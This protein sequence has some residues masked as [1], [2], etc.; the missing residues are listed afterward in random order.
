[1]PVGAPPSAS[2]SRTESTSPPRGRGALQPRHG[3]HPLAALGHDRGVHPRVAERGQQLVARERTRVARVAQPLELVV[4]PAT[5]EHV[6]HRDRP[7]G[8]RDA[9]HLGRGPRRLVDVMEREPADDDVEL[10]VA[11][12]E[13]GR[14]AFDEHDVAAS[15]RHPGR[16][17]LARQVDD[18][19]E[20][21]PRGQMPAD[22]PRAAGDVEH[23]V[24]LGHRHVL[25][26]P[27]QHVAVAEE[28]VRPL[29]LTDLPRELATRDRPL[30][31]ASGA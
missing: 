31:H 23:H 2:A 3:G 29:E 13:R 20:P 22:V 25:G 8:P 12:R 24:G 1:M 18:D 30:I 17:H 28:R 10:P 11:E 9:R 14:V 27:R 21:R 6:D 26:D 5:V 16:E 7:A 4:A 15:R 19:R